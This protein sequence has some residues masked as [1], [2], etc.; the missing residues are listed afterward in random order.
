MTNTL[1]IIL[2]TIGIYIIYINF[3]CKKETFAT[4]PSTLIQLRSTSTENLCQH[5]GGNLEHKRRNYG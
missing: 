1:N 4:S 3:L 5:C 2:I